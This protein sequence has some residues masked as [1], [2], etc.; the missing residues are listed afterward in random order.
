MKPPQKPVPSSASRVLGE[1]QRREQPE[2]ERAGD[3]DDERAPRDSGRRAG[4]RRRT[5]AARRRRRRARPAARSLVTALGVERAPLGSGRPAVRDGDRDQA[6]GQGADQVAPPRGRRRPA[7]SSAR[8][9]SEYADSVVNPP[10][11]PGPEPDR[12]HPAAG[13]RP[14]A[15]G[16]SASAKEPTT[17]IAKV[18]HGN[19][20]ASA[21]E[22]LGEPPPGQRPERAT[23]RHRGHQPRRRGAGGHETLLW[24]GSDTGA[25]C[26]ASGGLAPLLPD[27]LAEEPA[28][29]ALLLGRAGQRQQPL[30][31]AE[32]VGEVEQLDE[33]ADRGRGLARHRDVQVGGGGA[34][35]RAPA[36]SGRRRC[37]RA[38]RARAS[39]RG[40]RG[41]WRAGSRSRAP[42]PAAGPRGAARGSGA[43]TRRTSAAVRRR[44]RCASRRATACAVVTAAARR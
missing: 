2:Q 13:V 39:R 27:E 16:S 25:S 23:D 32:R 36:R 8:V 33:P 31:A 19:A 35:R 14:R 4:W 18:V 20:S 22:G 11:T 12:E 7:S 26:H 1:R 43:G 40:R 21:R 3:V 30:L 5:A 41:P 28:L 17:L 29:E 6:G 34:G 24:S 38:G 44:C 37:P 9:C 15:A 10:S 42:A